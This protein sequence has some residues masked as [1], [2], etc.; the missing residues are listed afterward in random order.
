MVY[1]RYTEDEKRSADPWVGILQKKFVQIQE[2]GGW[3][4]KG[5]LLNFCVD[6]YANT[7][8]NHFKNFVKGLGKNDKI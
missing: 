1:R 8:I 7:I 4:E 2:E 3:Y 6:S 5:L